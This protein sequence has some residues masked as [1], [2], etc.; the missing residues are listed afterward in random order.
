MTLDPETVRALPGVWKFWIGI[1]GYA[2]FGS[3]VK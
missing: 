3:A 1:L 2:V